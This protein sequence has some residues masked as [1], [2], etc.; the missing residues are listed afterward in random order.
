MPSSKKILVVDGDALWRERI[1]TSLA[2][3]LT[4]VESV[5]TAA[6]ALDYARR[7]KPDLIATE[8]A[9][10]DITG[11]GLCRLVREEP[12]LLHTGIL[13]VTGHASEIDRILAFENGVDDFLA[14]PFYPRELASR[15]GAVLRRSSGLRHAI[16]EGEPSLGGGPT[17]HIAAGSIVVGDQRLELTPR[18]HNLLAALIRQAGRVVTRRQLIEMVWGDDAAHTDRVIDAHVKAIRRKLGDA[19]ECLETVRGVGY[20]FSELGRR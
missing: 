6:E 13:M 5:A 10:P 18:E 17:V 14:K 16:G 8:L 9:L 15:V 1:S 12:A 19:K 20:R 2:S 4:T 3:P 11:I 7:E